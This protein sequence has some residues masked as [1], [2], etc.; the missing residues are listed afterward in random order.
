MGVLFNKDRSELVITCNCGCD[1]GVH[2]KIDHD[3]YDYFCLMSYMNGNFYN[4][5]NKKIIRVIEEKAKKIWAI[6]RNKDHYYSDIIMTKDQWKEFKEF[7]NSV[8]DN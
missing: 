8:D 3:D 1:E 4:D 6:I 5:Q 7:I 2:I